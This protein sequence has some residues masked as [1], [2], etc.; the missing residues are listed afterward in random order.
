M[1]VKIRYTVKR[2]KRKNQQGETFKNF[3]ISRYQ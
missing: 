1:I 3:T 2:A